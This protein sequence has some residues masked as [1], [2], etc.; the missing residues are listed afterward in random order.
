M[1]IR[2][3][4]AA[5]VIGAGRG[6]GTALCQRLASDGYKVAAMGRTLEKDSPLAQS[7]HAEF[8]DFLA[9][10]GDATEQQ[11]V[12]AAKEKVESL[13]GSI[14]VVVYNAGRLHLGAFADTEAQIFE[15]LWRVNCFGAVLAAKAFLPDMANRG[16][17][18]FIATG[19]T[20]SLRGGAMAS[21]FSASK[22]ALRGLMQSLARTYA[23]KGVH[24]AHVVIDGKIWGAEA[25]SPYIKSREEAMEA[26]DA[27]EA[28]ANLIA[29]PRSAWTQ[30]LDLRPY[31]E[32]F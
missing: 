26:E 15:E 3:N 10:S 29:Q 25:S 4:G 32:S 13:F 30:E 19:A 16:A 27:A 14:D 21:A 18:T 11:D 8:G 31:N 5:F 2:K 20:A 1:T 24:V 28:Y 7:M 22:F 12:I 6:L 17:G 23:P 9:V